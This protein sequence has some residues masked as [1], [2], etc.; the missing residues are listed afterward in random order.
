M[1][2]TIGPLSS[3]KKTYHQLCHL[4]CCSFEEVLLNVTH[5][6]WVTRVLCQP[7]AEVLENLFVQISSIS[8]NVVG[9]ILPLHTWKTLTQQL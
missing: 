8:C 6:M 9:S 3:I 1:A 7:V 4:T 5:Q 2:E